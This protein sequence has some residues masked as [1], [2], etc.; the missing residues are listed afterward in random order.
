MQMIEGKT[1]YGLEDEIKQTAAGTLVVCL[2]T[3]TNKN[4][5]CLSEG[6]GKK[7]LVV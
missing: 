6:R 5:C 7:K 4:H 1:R 3:G 2:Q